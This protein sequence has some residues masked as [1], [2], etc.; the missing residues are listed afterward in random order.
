[1]HSACTMYVCG[2]YSEQDN[3]KRA[4]VISRNQQSCDEH[5]S[6]KEDESFLPL[7]Q[8]IGR[9]GQSWQHREMKVPYPTSLYTQIKYTPKLH[10]CITHYT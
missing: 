5:K 10:T 3:Y 7:V 9:L 8:Y 6:H 2:E 4:V 1:M